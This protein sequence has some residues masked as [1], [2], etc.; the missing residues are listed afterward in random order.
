[1]ET[2][3]DLQNFHIVPKRNRIVGN[4]VTVTL[5]DISSVTNYIIFY[6]FSFSF[7]AILS[8]SFVT[9][10]PL[11]CGGS[12]FTP[13]FGNWFKTFCLFIV[14]FDV[15]G[16]SS[17]RGERRQRGE[18]EE[19]KERGE[20]KEREERKRRESGEREERICVAIYSL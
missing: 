12:T 9:Q 18:R 1:M 6:L 11:P 16:V 3:I 2:N 17:R 4:R 8:C 10:S 20:R 13:L 7:N 5:R 15:L 14:G 19:R